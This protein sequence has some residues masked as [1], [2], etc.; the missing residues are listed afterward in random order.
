MGNSLGGL[1]GG[2]SGGSGGYGHGPELQCCDAVVD[3]ISLL[4]TIAG[5]AALALFMRQAVIDN[6]IMGRRKRKR[7]IP[8]YF[9]VLHSGTNRS[10]GLFLVLSKSEPKS[11]KD[12]DGSW[13]IF[14]IQV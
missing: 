4:T 10:F 1:L 12:S 9:E 13:L 14:S 2:S 8:S 3:P 6:M 5:I 11:R 7:S